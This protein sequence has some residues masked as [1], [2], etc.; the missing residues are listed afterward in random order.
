[1]HRLRSV[2]LFDLTCMRNKAWNGF[3]PKSDFDARERLHKVIERSVKRSGVGALNVSNISREVGITRP[4]FYRYFDSVE[5]LIYSAITSANDSTISRLYKR[6]ER[7]NTPA[8]RAVESV[9]FLYREI[10]K[11]QLLA[12]IFFGVTPQKQDVDR[13][14]SPASLKRATKDLARI[15]GIENRDKAS[16]EN[17]REVTHMVLRILWSL[18]T[19]PDHQL[20]NENDLRALLKNWIGIPIEVLFGNGYGRTGRDLS[21]Q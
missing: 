7:F 6:A 8:E 13:V 20:K 21:P 16:R 10:P 2:V 11:D 9:I 5:A 19:I 15:L 18:L 4:T 17:L 1:V 12:A 3:P 14:F